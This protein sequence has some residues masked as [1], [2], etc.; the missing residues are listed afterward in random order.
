[1]YL[2]GIVVLA[3]FALLSCLSRQEEGGFL[4]RISVYLYKKGCIHK[5]PLLNAHHVQRDLESLHPGQSGLLLQGDYYIQ[6][7]RLLLLV[8]GVGTLLGVAAHARSDIGGSLT[9]QGELLRP[10]TGQGESQVK[11]RTWLEGKELGDITVT[12]PERRLTPQEAQELYEEFWELWKRETL[13]DNSSWQEIS[14]SLTPMEE[15][16][17]YPFTVSWK[18]SDYEVLGRSGTVHNP[19]TSMPVTLTV[20]SSYLDFCW[21]EE[22]DL[23]VVPRS[24]GEGELLAGQVLDAYCLAEEAAASQ[25]RIPLPEKLEGGKLSWQE[26]REDHSLLLMLMT[27]VTAAAVFLF[28]DRDLHRQV[29]K[30]R[31]KMKGNYPVVLNKFILYLG[32]GMTIRGAFQKIAL[33]YYS[34]QKGAPQPLY[35]EMVYACNR[36][37]AGISESRVYEM[38]AAR[39]G[40]QDCARLSTMLVQN[41]KKGNAALLP[42]LRE[43]GDK[44]LQEDLNLRRKKGEEAGTRL[45]VPMIMM[46]AIVMV[47]V[48]VPAFQGFGL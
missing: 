30:R 40:L 33:D 48:M 24:L 9:D 31:E 38:W 21:Q 44:A 25:D 11:L 41:L 27:A 2:I 17:G 35:E 28:Q 4:R 3:G 14:H 6:K 1:M 7:L 37:Q 26:V 12:V 29:L 15:L 20:Q 36:L 5:I 8:L 22:L 47:L 45:L 42:R 19:Q 43:E 46:M 32:A 18:S 16:E 10:L 39:T 34:R 13:G 23:L